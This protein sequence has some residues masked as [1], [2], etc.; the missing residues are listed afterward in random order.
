MSGE[1]DVETVCEHPVFEILDKSLL[2]EKRALLKYRTAKLW[3][4]YMTMIYLLH[5]FLKAERA[6]VTGSYI[7]NQ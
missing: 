3:L 5:K 1:I 2:N 6:L 7:F 4:Q